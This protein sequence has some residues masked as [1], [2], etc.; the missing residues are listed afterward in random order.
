MAA[1]K[2]R[3][4]AAGRCAGPVSRSPY[5]A[6]TCA[7]M[8]CLASCFRRSRWYQLVG[9]AGSATVAPE[10]TARSPAESPSGW[11]HTTSA[12]PHAL[13]QP[14]SPMRRELTCTGIDCRH[15]GPRGSSSKVA[16]SSTTARPARR[17]MSPGPGVIRRACRPAPKATEARIMASSAARRDFRDAVAT[18]PAARSGTNTQ[19]ETRSRSDSRTPANTP[20]ATRTRGRPRADPTSATQNGGSPDTFAGAFTT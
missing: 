10:K 14:P 20:R 7:W 2:N 15:D 9:S 12:L 11:A 13:C 5:S 1:R 17:E 4:S 3:R 19:G 16:L 6:F 8:P 18:S